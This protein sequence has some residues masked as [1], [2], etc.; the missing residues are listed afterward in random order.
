MKIVDEENV[1]MLSMDG[2]C[3]R[4]LQLFN[5]KYKNKFGQSCATRGA[6]PLYFD[7]GR[8]YLDEIAIAK[9]VIN[10]I[11]N[12]GLTE[13]LRNTGAGVYHCTDCLKLV[14]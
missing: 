12:H 7:I 1:F 13:L 2:S 9:D 8:G 4:A 14:L 3:A 6:L 10:F 11:A 5:E